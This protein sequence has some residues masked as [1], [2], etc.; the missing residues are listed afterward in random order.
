[1]IERKG[2]LFAFDDAGSFFAEITKYRRAN[3]E[4]KIF[5]QRKIEIKQNKPQCYSSHNKQK[6]QPIVTF[7]LQP[8][9]QANFFAEPC[10]RTVGRQDKKI[11]TDAKQ[12]AINDTGDQDPFPQP[13]LANKIMRIEKR[14]YGNDDF[15]EQ[16]VDLWR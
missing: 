4:I 16:A 12:Y 8:C 14:L 6:T 3:D 15:F 2:K 7:F 10:Y 5:E 13:V 9:F 1:M 11:K